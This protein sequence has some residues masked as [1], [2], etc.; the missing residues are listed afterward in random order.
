[1]R[2]HFCT[3]GEFVL[4]HVNGLST[5]LREQSKGHFNFVIKGAIL[6]HVLYVLQLRTTS[7]SEGKANYRKDTVGINTNFIS[8]PRL[9]TFVSRQ[10]KQGRHCR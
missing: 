9:P 4:Q 10:G 3:E 5:L 6:Y 1:M 7:S 2:K 8:T